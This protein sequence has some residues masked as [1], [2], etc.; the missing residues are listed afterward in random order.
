MHS[1]RIRIIAPAFGGIPLHWNGSDDTIADRVEGFDA[2]KASSVLCSYK[3]IQLSNARLCPDA[4]PQLHMNQETRP[5]TNNANGDAANKDDY[6]TEA[7]VALVRFVHHSTLTSKDKMIEELRA[8]SAALFSNRAKATR[9]LDAIAV[10]KKHPK[11]AGVYW[12][13]KTEI[14]AQLGLNDL[15]EKKAEDISYDDTVPEK[16]VPSSA[17]KKSKKDVQSPN[18]NT[19]TNQGVKVG[20]EATE[21]ASKKRKATNDKTKTPEKQTTSPAKKKK[22]G[23]E[24]RGSGKKESPKKTDVCA[25][26][27]NVM[28][29]FVKR[30]PA[31]TTCTASSPNDANPSPTPTSTSTSQ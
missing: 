16:P 8:S 27:K 14:L 2:E 24:G 26:M 7:M 19:T 21:S 20:V 23:N 12:E 6:S 17:D 29:Q 31:K 30:S 28:A 1:N 11:Y 18:T 3:G 13:V 10:K 5:E 4:F 22:A 15:V 9:K 25:G